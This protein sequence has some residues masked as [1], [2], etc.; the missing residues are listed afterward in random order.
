LDIVWQYL[1]TM[2]ML[3]PTNQQT[4]VDLCFATRLRLLPHPWHLCY[5][6]GDL[7]TADVIFVFI[8]R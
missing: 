5:L 7:I 2:N 6:A 3:A 1:V 4:N 8:E